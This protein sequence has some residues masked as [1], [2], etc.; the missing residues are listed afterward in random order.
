M[1]SVMYNGV[2]FVALIY[3]LLSK[4]HGNDLDHHRYRSGTF[5]SLMSDQNTVLSGCIDAFPELLRLRRTLKTVYARA[6]GV[7]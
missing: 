7:P 6:C 5:P 1:T 3:L 4:C 2:D